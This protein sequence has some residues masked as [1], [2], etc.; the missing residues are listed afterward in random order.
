MN[1][2]P[3]SAFTLHAALAAFFLLP[4][5]AGA[6][7]PGVTVSSATITIDPQTA[8]SYSLQGGFTGLSFSDAQVVNWSVGQFSGSIPISAFAQDP[9]TGALTYHDSTGQAPGWISSLTID[10]ASLTFTAQTSGV[11][12]AGLPNPFAVQLGTDSASA[13]TMARVQTVDGTTFR[14]TAG[15]DLGIPCR[16]PAPPQVSQPSFFAGEPTD[17]RFRVTILP[18]A[19]LDPA[20]VQIFRVDA[21]A[22]PMGSPLCVLR[23]SGAATDGDSTAGDGV[24]S[25]IVHFSE[26]TPGSIPL[27]AQATAGAG[28]L[29]SQGFSVLAVAPMSQADVDALA[30]TQ[31]EADSAWLDNFTAFG[32][33]A[34]SRIQTMAALR[35]LPGVAEVRLLEDG[36]SIGVQLTSGVKYALVLNR[37]SDGPDVSSANRH[38][39]PAIASAT[40]GRARAANDASQLPPVRAADAQPA[41]C[42]SP[43]RP[44][45][46]NNA[47]LIW[48]SGFF[49]TPN[50]SSVAMDRFSAVKCPGF[51]VDHVAASI[52]NAQRFPSYGTIIIETH[53]T[54]WMNDQAFVT[55]DRVDLMATPW[56]DPRWRGAQIGGT[57][58]AG[59]IPGHQGEAYW[60]LTPQFFQ[61]LGPFQKTIVFA[62]ACE[63]G[64]PAPIPFIDAGA[65]PMADVLAANGGAYFGFTDITRSA[66]IQLVA[67]S[68]FDHLLK[69]YWTVADAYQAEPHT[70]P[71]LQALQNFGFPTAQANSR[72][73]L[74]NDPANKLAYLGNPAIAALST[75]PSFSTGTAGVLNLQAQLE[76]A[77]GCDGTMNYMWK[78]PATVG[79]LTPAT[80]GGLDAFTTLSAMATYTALP[81]TTGGNENLMV[82]FLPDGSDPVPAR[83]CTTINVPKKCIAVI[84]NG[85]GVPCDFAGS[86][87]SGSW[88]LQLT[89][90]GAAPYGTFK[91]TFASVPKAGGYGVASGGVISASATIAPGGLGTNPTYT[92]S[93]PGPMSGFVMELNDISD[94]TTPHGDIATGGFAPGNLNISLNFVF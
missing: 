14:L 56:S 47:V 73:V 24:Y 28:R 88:T 29:F 40:R 83:A 69:D 45:V 22:Q 38:G 18:T 5:A 77:V 79:H 3:R 4:V 20:S 13:C 9:D 57:I 23:D 82:D 16:M 60:A 87:A 66:F 53:G 30:S 26:A 37:L 54:V 17:V 92:M 42:N 90:I 91:I 55:S 86:T 81:T 39:H 85:Q 46:R 12:L 75:P 74:Q 67:P 10:P 44:V 6:Q 65:S 62:G 63:S 84:G 35:G 52:A 72:F 49:P 58:I 43:A 25:C 59:G 21:N 19:N 33:T 68:L 64:R 70:D 93:F 31:A 48:D 32:D 71:L 1:L 34:Q 15:D 50:V 78:N 80:G 11:I 94:P 2:I 7:T 51:F 89:T 8:D 36:L 41:A 27:L 61:A 76:G